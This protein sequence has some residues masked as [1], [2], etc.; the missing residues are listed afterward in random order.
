MDTHAVYSPLDLFQL[1]F[2]PATVLTL[3]TNTNKRAAKSK[4]MGKKYKWADVDVEELYKF[5]ELLTYTSLVSLPSIAD[6]WKQ[7]TTASVPFPATVMARDHF[8]A[9]LWNIHPS[10]PEEDEKNDEKKGTSGYGKLFRIKPLINDIISACQAYYHP[11]RELAVDERMVATKAKTGMTQFMKE[12]PTRWGIK[13]FVLA[14]SSNG[15]TVNFNIY[16]GKTHTHSAWAL[17]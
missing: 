12:K 13:L 15:Y 10:D 17:I 3:C 6:Y 11:R 7:N 5:L 16:T 14:D 2:S 1:Y 4:E 9:L 8:R